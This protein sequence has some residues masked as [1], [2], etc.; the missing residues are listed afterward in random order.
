MKE[1][2]S[3]KTT[4]IIVIILLLAI[5]SFS[6]IKDFSKT[7]EK[8]SIAKTKA[9]NY[10]K[11]KYNMDVKVIS[12]SFPKGLFWSVDVY[13]VNDKEKRPIDIILSKTAI[14]KGNL[15][16]PSGDNYSEVYWEKEIIE[17]L[18][19]KFGSFSNLDTVEKI[20]F[21]TGDCHTSLKEGVSADKDKNRVFIPLKPPFEISISFKLDPFSDE[22][23][24]DLLSM[25]K[26]ISDGDIDVHLYMSYIR[27]VDDRSTGDKIERQNYFDLSFEELKNIR[28]LDDLK[29]LISKNVIL[30]ELVRNNPNFYNLG[31]KKRVFL[32][33][34]EPL[35]DEVFMDLLQV[36]KNIQNGDK[37]FDYL[38]IKDKYYKKYMASK[39]KKEIH[40]YI[41]LQYEEFKNIDDIYELKQIIS[42]HR[43]FNELREKHQSLFN[44]RYIEKVN[45]NNNNNFKGFDLYMDFWNKEAFSD[46]LLEELI[47]MIKDMQS[48]KLKINL[49]LGDKYYERTEN[50]SW[51]TKHYIE[52]NYT[53]FDNIHNLEDLREIISKYERK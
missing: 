35:T 52:I 41:K 36:I 32:F 14:K 23:L 24:K 40:H 29:S 8:K 49:L 53:D 43:N 11:E 18:E 38:V 17:K 33:E 37:E 47:F 10:M 26:D 44:S 13:D 12:V 34:K 20:R 46:N 22:V 39:E 31:D 6:I 42:L 4:T 27:Y 19:S 3:I 51:L 5:V 50:S 45:I 28:S 2:T 21:R 7:Q 16:G 9:I 1:K 25:I 15:E 48:E 30:D